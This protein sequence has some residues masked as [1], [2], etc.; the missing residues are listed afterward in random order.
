MSKQF[1]LDKDIFT[2]DNIYKAWLNFRKG[3]KY[4]QDVVDFEL[5]LISN[6][7]KLREDLVSG[8]YTHDKYRHF[9]ITETKKREIH[10][11]SVR[12]RVVHH[13]LYNTLYSYFDKKFIYDS[14]SCR[15]DKGTHKALLRYQHFSRKVSNNYTKQVHVL[16]FDIQKCFASIN[17]NILKSVL[18]RY[19]EDK[20]ILYL[21]FKIIDSH[22]QGI[23]L[24]NLTSQLF[25]NI[26][27][28]ELDF[29]CKHTLKLKYYIRYADDVVI[30]LDR[31]EVDK[32]QEDEYEDKAK[33]TINKIGIFC[34]VNLKLN[35]HKVEVKTMYSGVDFL[36]W[37]HF[38]K[39][40]VLRKV[41]KSKML[42]KVIQKNI[43][44]YIGLLKWG[45][46]WKLKN[47]I[48]KLLKE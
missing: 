33:E 39:F 32:K 3:K 19:I 40:R 26:Y 28:H 17:H 7:K 47:K 18:E 34:N 10:K 36:G 38:P 46:G 13:L 15:K 22:S 11:A 27:L 5:N 30:F 4:K 44:S 20:D 25:V 21:L 14:Y 2:S 37:I 31:K 8:R 1:I 35:I 48:L 9:T 29:Y 23:P 45:S 41:T 24:G 6:L 12:D 16:K 42:K 43:N